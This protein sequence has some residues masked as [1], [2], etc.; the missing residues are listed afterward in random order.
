ME[1]TIERLE[2]YR[3]LMREITILR[4]ELNEMNTT[5]AGLGSSVINDYRGGYAQPQAVVGF[6]SERY[7]RKRR[8][9]DKKETEVEEI[10]KWVEAI[11][12][13]VT[14][15]VF[16]YYYLEGLPWKEIAKRLGYRDNPDYPRIMI[17]DTY[18]KKVGMK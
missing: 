16:E 8:L 4:W 12:D 17:R 2:S 13:T 5:D 3:R 11:E 15:K 9:L 10:R 7:R 6:D 14:R 18:L 1:M